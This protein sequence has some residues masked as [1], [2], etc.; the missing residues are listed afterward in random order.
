MA[1]LTTIF[2]L[3]SFFASAQNIKVEYDKDRDLSAYKTFSMGEM[4]IITPKDQ[5]QPNEKSLKET[6]KA[7]LIEELTEKG[8][9]QV[10]SA[11]DLVVSFLAGSEQRM[12][13]QRVGPLGGTPGSSNDTWSRDFIMENI[14]IDL[15]D[16]SK[17]LIWRVK[18][19]S[20]SSVGDMESAVAS[21]VS[22]GFKKFS[23]KPKKV[24]KK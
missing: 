3:M 2:L 20:T 17:K 11:G 6:I 13:M 8:L 22:A 4:E 16:K 18:A 14:I 21:V 9:H 7:E 24:K 1:R 19:S 5:I 10:D 12:D 15:N 23:R